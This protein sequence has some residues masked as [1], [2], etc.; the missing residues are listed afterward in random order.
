MAAILR[1]WTHKF[2][3]RAALY[4]NYSTHLEQRP[5]LKLLKMVKN[6]QKWPKMTQNGVW[7]HF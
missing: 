7:T 5:P 3:L 6:G 2:W 4:P 1:V